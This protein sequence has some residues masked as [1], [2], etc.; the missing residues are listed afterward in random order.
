MKM[1]QKDTDVLVILFVVLLVF[2]AVSFLNKIEL[3]FPAE[4]LGLLCFAEAAYILKENS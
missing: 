2:C 4:V 1:N 3:I